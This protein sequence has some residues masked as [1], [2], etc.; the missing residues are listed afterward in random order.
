[1]HEVSV[2]S[3][4]QMVNCEKCLKFFFKQYGWKYEPPSNI[5]GNQLTLFNEKKRE[6]LNIIKNDVIF[7]M[8]T[9]I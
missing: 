5:D 6:Q 8:F 3:D 2:P 7:L 4:E 9:N 1:M